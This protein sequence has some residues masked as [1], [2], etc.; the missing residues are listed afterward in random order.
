MTYVWLTWLADE[1]RAEGCKVREYD[2]WK[3]RGRPSSTGSFNPYGVLQHHTGTKTSYNNPAPTLSTCVHG[4]SDLPGPLCQVMIGYDGTCHVIAAG[5]ANHG[6]EC[7]GNG[8][9][10]QGDANAQLVGFELDYSG[11]QAVSPEQADAA[12]RAAA[13]VLRRFGRDE[14]YCRGHKETSTTGKWDPGR[15][16]SSDP[17]YRMDEV[18]GY[19]KDRLAGGSGDDDMPEYVSL[20]GPGFTVTAGADW[21]PVKMSDDNADSGEVHPDGYAW[22]NLAG[23]KYVGQVR[24]NDCTSADRDATLVVRW[25]EYER[26]G[27]QG[28]TSAPAPAEHALT[29]G[30]T[31]IH[32]EVID[33]CSGGHRVRVEVKARTADVVIGSTGLTAVYWR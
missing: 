14:S 28:F 26:E 21:A 15:N 16:G 13:A 25:A 10:T 2:G 32:D 12:I 7:N 20:G 11:S 17:A 3:S 1:L 19:I 18:R 23:A 29:T 31:G 5:R 8:P 30:T 9:F 27:D 6:G 4:R 24:F 22:L 33:S